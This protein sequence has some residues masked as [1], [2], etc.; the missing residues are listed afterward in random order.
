M[1]ALDDKITELT[2][3]VAND[4]TVI[5]SAITLINGFAQRLAEAIAAALAAGASE[6]QLQ[7]LTD[8]K[9]GLAAN[10]QA[11]ADAVAAN[12]PAT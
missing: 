1:S 12:T 3:E 2:N 11:L 5:Q 10:D 8:L 6:A 7:S 9:T 4:T